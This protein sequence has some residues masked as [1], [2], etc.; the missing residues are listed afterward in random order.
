MYVRLA[1]AVAGPNLPQPGKYIVDVEVE[2]LPLAPDMYTLDIGCRS[3]DSHALDYIP[4]EV[5][6]NVVQAPRLPATLRKPC[7]RASC[8]PVVME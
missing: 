2:G 5:Q 3:G 4:T 1:F 7:G 8:K 6:L